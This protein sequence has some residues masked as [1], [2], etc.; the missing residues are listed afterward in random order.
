MDSKL[1]QAVQNEQ[2]IYNAHSFCI[3]TDKIVNSDGPLHKNF[4]LLATNWDADGKEYIALVEHK[5]LPIYASQ[6]HP[7][8]NAF[9]WSPYV[10][11]PH[12]KNAILFMQY[13]ANFLVEEARQSKHQFPESVEFYKRSINN[14]SP[15]Y[16]LIT[17]NSTMES[18][19]FFPWF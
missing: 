8:K 10:A 15:V 14:Y 1:Y 18:C 19:Y 17:I 11:I 5:R 13:L 16:T 12:S 3:S 9:E 6:F 2:L 4:N 7:E